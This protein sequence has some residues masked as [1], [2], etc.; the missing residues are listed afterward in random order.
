MIFFLQVEFFTGPPLHFL[1]TKFLYNRQHLEK[2]LAKLNG[3]LK[4]EN[5]G[6][7]S[8]KS[9]P[10]DVTVDNK[11]ADNIFVYYVPVHNKRVDNI[12]VDKIP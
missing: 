7:T 6:G 3:I 12:S 5:L 10:V 11:P 8:K 2:F 1:S 9:H 4:I